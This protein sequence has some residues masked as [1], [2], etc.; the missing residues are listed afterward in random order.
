MITIVSGRDPDRPTDCLIS[1]DGHDWTATAQLVRATAADLFTVAAYADMII[2]L[3]VETRLD[4]DTASAL[5]G[6]LIVSQTGRH[7]F[8]SEHTISLLPAGSTKKR[9]GMVHIRRGRLDGV[10]DTAAARHM[11]AQWLTVAEAAESDQLVA[12]ALRTAGGIDE[13]R[14]DGLFAYLRELRSP[15]HGRPGV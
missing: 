3:V 4:P 14:I 10:V 15:A 12:E 2:H 5:A 7:A 13:A 11:G 8:G 9:K 6:D 1:W